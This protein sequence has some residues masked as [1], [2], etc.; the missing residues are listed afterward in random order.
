VQALVAVVLSNLGLMAFVEIYRPCRV[1]SANVLDCE[2]ISEIQEDTRGRRKQKGIH[3]T[4]V[5]PALHD[6]TWLWLNRSS[7]ERFS[8]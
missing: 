7:Q 1:D 8:A 2:A 4:V 3:R 6:I 5:D